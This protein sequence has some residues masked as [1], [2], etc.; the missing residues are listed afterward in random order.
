MPTPATCWTCRL[1]RKKCDRAVPTCKACAT[2]KI[3]CHCS[4]SR[5][6]WMDGGEKQSDMA[7]RVRAEIRQGAE[8]RRERQYIQVMTLHDKPLNA[9]SNSSL[10][11]DVNDQTVRK[12]FESA[13]DPFADMGN[14]THFTMM[15]LDHVF[16]FLFPFCQ[17]SIL[18]GGR[19]WLLAMLRHNEALYHSAM[20]LSSYFLPLSFPSHLACLMTVASRPCG[21][22]WNGT[23]TRRSGS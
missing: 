7:Q 21:T 6:D 23:W 8:A 16:P 5:P 13:L 9:E 4:E 12:K 15:Y 3:T 11:L 17:P 14:Q 22:H 2:L 10:P 18:E 19:A 1:R 20:S